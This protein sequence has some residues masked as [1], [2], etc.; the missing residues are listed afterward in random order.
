MQILLFPRAGLS[1]TIPPYLSFS[2]HF[3]SLYP[4]HPLL[5]HYL[6]SNPHRPCPAT[7]CLSL[8]SVLSFTWPFMWLSFLLMACPKQPSRLPR[9]FSQIG[10]TSRSCHL[11]FGQGALCTD[12]ILAFCFSN[13]HYCLGKHSNRL[14]VGL[15]QLW[16]CW[17]CSY[18]FDC[19]IQI[20]ACSCLGS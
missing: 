10:T 12:T 11:G 20:R 13:I 19:V 8:P 2:P 15:C 1:H 5:A 3:R 7:S 9:S 17:I 16:Y 4:V 14:L 6:S 18:I